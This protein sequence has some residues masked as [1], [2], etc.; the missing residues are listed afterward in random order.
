MT[1]KMLRIVLI[2]DSRS[3]ADIIREML[4]DTSIEHQLTWLSD[5]EK[6]M[7]YFNNGGSADFILLDLNLPRVHGHQLLDFLKEKGVHEDK[8]IIVSG[9]NSPEDIERTKQKGVACYIV[10]P[11]GIEEME[12]TADEL[13]KIL[14]R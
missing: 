1:A 12:R 13:K 9:S 2:E 8:V 10:K 3:D 6:A 7:E 4:N 14:A 11:M 5:G